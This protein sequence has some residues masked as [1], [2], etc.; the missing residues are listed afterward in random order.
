MTQVYRLIFA[1]VWLQAD[2]YGLYICRCG[3]K[4]REI[5]VLRCMGGFRW[6]GKQYG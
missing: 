4:S 5:N 1:C 6:Y 2:A 3:Q